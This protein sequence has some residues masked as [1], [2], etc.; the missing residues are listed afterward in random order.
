MYQAYAEYFKTL[1]WT[2]VAAA[3][4]DEI[5]MAAR[6]VVFRQ[7]LFIG[8]IFL[9]SII[10]TY[11]LQ[12]RISR[13]LKKLTVYARA[14]P[15]QDFVTD[16]PVDQPSELKDLAARFRDEVGELAGAFIFMEDA[17]RKYIHDLRETTAAKERIESEL[18]IARDI[19][20]SILPKLFPAFPDRWEFDV[21][22]MVQ[23]AREVGGDFY[24]YFFV[25]E[26]HLFF[27]LGDVSGKGVPASLFMAVTKTLLRASVAKDMRPDKIL[28]R[29]NNMLCEGNDAC[30]FVTVFC[31]ILDVRTGVVLCANGGH[32]PS[33]EVRTGRDVSFLKMPSGMAMGIMEDFRFETREIVLQPGDTLFMYTDGVTEAMNERQ[34]LF[35]EE[36]LQQ[37]VFQLCDR[38]IRDMTHGMME[39][40]EVFCNEEP[41]SDDIT[42]LALRYL[43]PEAHRAA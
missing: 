5:T 22:A 26:D 10:L 15:E 18:Q 35:S 33:L 27:S 41:Q 4:K 17:L 42:M 28:A 36:R 37:C 13:H 30:M 34:E 20:M 3:R 12:G 2:I 25:D 40:I 23:P 7:S 32:N 21:Y 24:D 6:T 31:G 9:V 1:D 43:G 19:Q 14:L 11:V 29:V 16:K 38:S 8:A 39:R